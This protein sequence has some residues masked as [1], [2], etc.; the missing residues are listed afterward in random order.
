MSRSR[1]RTPICGNTTAHSDHTW[2]KAVARLVR[3]RV[4]QLLRSDPD[5][6]PLAGKRWELVNPWDCEKDGKFWFGNRRPEL[7]RK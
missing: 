6:F 2:K 5:H 4:R 3:R 7:L 1:R